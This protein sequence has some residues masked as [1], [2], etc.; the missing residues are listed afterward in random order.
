MFNTVSTPRRCARRRRVPG[1][2]GSRGG[3]VRGTVGFAAAR[4]AGGGGGLGGGGVG[5]GAGGGGARGAVGSRRC[6]A[7]RGDAGKTRHMTV[8]V[9]GLS[10]NVFTTTVTA[11][12]H[13]IAADEP[14][15]LGGAD[16]GITP[17]DLLLASLGS[18]TV[19]T[20]RIYAR[21]RGYPLTGATVTLSHDRIHAEDCANCETS[22]GFLDHI[23]RE[24]ALA[25]DLTPEQRADLLRI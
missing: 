16:T 24:I 12:R 4:G 11:G 14:V 21:R 5:G 17:Y 13:R 8:T 9:H 1:T 3:G 20:V 19:M 25:G 2:W 18:C 10:G 7:R 23:T 22:V 6:A 15:D